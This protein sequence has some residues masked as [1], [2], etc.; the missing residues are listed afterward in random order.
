MVVATQGAGPVERPSRVLVPTDGSPL[1]RAGLELAVAYAKGTGARVSLL[2][3]VRPRRLDVLEPGGRLPQ[4]VSGRFAAV[5]TD[6]VRQ[7]LSAVL[8]DA[9]GLDLAIVESSDATVAI[10]EHARAGGFDL[11]VVGAHDR[12][13]EQRLFLGYGAELLVEQSPCTTAVVLPKLRA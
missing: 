8:P 11:L 10:L 2:H 5:E 3:V 6:R 9:A 12:A 1:A 7:N 4:S 13:I